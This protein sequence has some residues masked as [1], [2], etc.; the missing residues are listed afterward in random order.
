MAWSKATAALLTMAPCRLVVVPISDPN[1][2]TQHGSI[3]LNAASTL[4][5]D[6]DTGL[7]PNLVEVYALGYT[8]NELPVV[9]TEWVDGKTAR[10]ELA[11]G[12]SFSALMCGTFCGSVSIEK[13]MRPAM[14]SVI[15]GAEPR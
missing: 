12:R 14:R 10:N 7:H 6:A 3:A 15:I 5:L 11:S 1:Y 2:V 8:A 4:Q 9:V 13:L